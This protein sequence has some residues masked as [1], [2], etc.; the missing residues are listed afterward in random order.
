LL[1]DT[2]IHTRKKKEHRKEKISI[3]WISVLAPS[4]ST[5]MKDGAISVDKSLWHHVTI[6]I[7][8][9]EC[10]I[11]VAKEF[12]FKLFTDNYIYFREIEKMSFVR[13]CRKCHVL[14]K[15]L[16]IISNSSHIIILS[17]HTWTQSSI[18]ILYFTRQLKSPIF[19]NIPRSYYSNVY[20]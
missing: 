16:E 11:F 5:I 18:Q 17:S 4:L 7:T 13:L 6:I 15:L 1:E 19:F 8:Y 14:S 12:L 9:T 10:K 3:G 2:Y 20:S